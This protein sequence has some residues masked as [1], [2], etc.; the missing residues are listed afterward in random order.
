[1]SSS[2]DETQ[3]KATKA[4]VHEPLLPAKW[5]V[6]QA[7]RWRLGDEAGRQRAMVS[8][9]HLLLV[10]HAPPRSGDST[11][12]GR[13]FWRDASSVWKPSGIKHGET[14]VGELLTEYD[15]AL[16][17]IEQLEDAAGTAEEYFGLLTRLNPMVRSIHNVYNALQNARQEL[18]EAR[19]L[20]LLRDRGYALTRRADLLQADAKNALEFVI[21]RQTEEQAKDARRQT[22][23][24]Y[25]LNMLA[26]LFFPIA[27]I[28]SVLSTGLGHG[29]ESY[30]SQYAP[31]PLIVLVSICLGL[32]FFLTGLVSRK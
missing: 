5:D 26:A 7:F 32:G 17:E 11:R 27:T 6:P 13:V 22:R 9:G 8:D 14:A 19:E 31:I 15:T 25:R 12:H 30:D 23:A 16:N 1:M 21:A 24:A 2:P 29:L 28:S 10:L 18:P 3:P 4:K 20:I